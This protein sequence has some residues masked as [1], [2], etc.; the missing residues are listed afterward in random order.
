MLSSI[1][2]LVVVALAAGV[3]WHC[4]SERVTKSLREADEPIG[5]PL[6]KL[7]VQQHSSQAVVVATVQQDDAPVSGAMVAFSRAIA[8]QA[9]AYQWS[10]MTDETG[11]ARVEIVSENATGYYRARASVDG[12]EIGSWL[13]IPVNGGYEVLLDLPIGGKARVMGSSRLASAGLTGEIPVGLVV[14]LTG[15]LASTGITM[16]HGF[17]LAREEINRSSLLGGATLKFII[18]DDGSTVEGA[19]AAF[20][21][22]IHRDN[23]PAILGPPTSSMTSEAFPIAQENGVVAISPTSAARG[24]SALGDFVFR[25]SLTVD[26]L[27]PGGVRTT[28]EKMGYQR[29]ATLFDQADVFSQS[30]DEAL[31]EALDE[32]GVEVLTTETFQTGDTDFSA[33]LNRIK[34]LNPDVIFVSALPLDIPEILIQGRHLGISFIVTLTLTIDEIQ[35]AGAAAEGVITF[36][37]WS[38]TA[39]TPGNQTFIENYRAKYGSEPNVFAAQA[40]AA[41][42]ILAKAIANA[43]S[44]DASAIRDALAMIR[45]LPTVLG[46]FSFDAHGDGV[47]DPAVLIVK[48]GNLEVFDP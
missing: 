25:A 17:E 13:S 11:Q 19:V 1:R 43:Q 8:G 28:H 16:R 37:S 42:Y 34:A 12:S 22:L 48:N 46:N 40:Y 15:R 5:Q 45:K 2:T 6:S 30:S 39:G 27:V 44:T 26:R 7:A 33:P 4:G 35:R 31:R 32:N 38:S 41:T 14:S 9:A 21:K 18:E 20:N 24:L 36:S 47:Y 29:V 10:G 23:V 3:M